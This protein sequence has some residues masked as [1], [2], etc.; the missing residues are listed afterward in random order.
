ML[1]LQ[2]QSSG[3]AVGFAMAGGTDP[4][5]WLCLLGGFRLVARGQ[6]VP[7]RSGGK[8]E[9]LLVH[10]G[11]AGFSGLPREMLLRTIWPQ[12]VPSL[13]SQA[14]SSLL[15]GLNTSLGE[16]L[17][18]AEPVVASAGQYRLN[19]AAGIAVDIAQFQALVAQGER[20]QRDNQV[21]AA[22]TVYERAVRLYQ[23]DLT[24]AAGGSARVALE[25]ERLRATY[26][27][28]LIRIADEAFA[29]GAFEASLEHA[30][31]LLSH[32]PCR[33][34]AHRLVM[35]CHVRLGERSQA[36]RHYQTAREI[37]RVE[38][39]AEPEPATTALFEQVR[40]QPGTV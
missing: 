31:A 39:D 30:L 21:T 7:V 19:E 28:V 9:A 32:D 34:D 29:H 23:G 40:L 13:A 18:G 11:L 15:R 27:R 1:R 5:V 6:P 37:L 26:C 2:S 3:V 14:L 25:R 38:H 12:S 33:E 20:L 8:T 16:A 24:V 17:A 36:L 4:L 35:R 22:T 10:L